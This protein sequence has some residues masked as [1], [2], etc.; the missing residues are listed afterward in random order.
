MSVL[1]RWF[2]EVWNQGRE[3]TIDEL[4]A[5]D[6]KVHGLADADGNEVSGVEPFRAY[7]RAFRTTFSDIH[8]DV[9]DIVTEGDL[10]VARFVVT[11][12]H[13]GEGLGKPPKGNPVEF[14]GMTMVRIE[15]GKLVEGWNNVDFATMVQQIG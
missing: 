11:A 5:P 12:R 1:K 7:W 6:A 10:S 14:S 8:I 9:Q 3:A 2:E 15:D 4:L 13:T